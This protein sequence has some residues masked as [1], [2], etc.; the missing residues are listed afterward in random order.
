MDGQRS[1][2]G[3]KGLLNF[4]FSFNGSISR[5]LFTGAFLSLSILSTIVGFVYSIMGPSNDIGNYVFGTLHIVLLVSL[6]SMGYKRAH[7]LGISGFYS[8]AGTMLFI[9]FFNFMKPARDFADDGSYAGQY[10]FFKSLGGSL[11]KTGI[12][13]FVSLTVVFATIIACYTV[14][15][16]EAFDGLAKLLVVIYVFNVVQ[17]LVMGSPFVKKYYASVVKVVSFLA[18][19][20]VVVS[21]ATSIF[22]VYLLM[23]ILQS[24]QGPVL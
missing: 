20:A 7:S 14:S 21:V 3:K 6:L 8:I 4:L 22:S 18:Y 9:P 23:A 2:S 19:N 12:R 17:M 16:R 10:P 11:I 15:N 24:M 1:G 5:E 13:Q